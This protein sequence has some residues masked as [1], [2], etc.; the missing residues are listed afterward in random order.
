MKTDH[1]YRSY[2]QRKKVNNDICVNIH[3]DYANYLHKILWWNLL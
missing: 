3:V 1:I 2:R